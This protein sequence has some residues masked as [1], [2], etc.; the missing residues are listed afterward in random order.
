MVAKAS[1]YNNYVAVIIVIMPWWHLCDCATSLEVN[2]QIIFSLG[3]GIYDLNNNTALP[4]NSL[5]LA[6]RIL[7]FNCVSGSSRSDV[8]D[9][10]DNR[11]RNISEFMDDPFFT[12]TRTV[13]AIHVQSFRRFN[14]NDEGIYTC[15]IPDDTGSIV[16]V[17]VGLYRNDTDGKQSS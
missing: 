8:G 2:C 5:I 3:A 4:N 14:F 15:R 9:V 6:G 12:F 16:D 10:F 17:H 13:G 7:D 11:Q 1:I